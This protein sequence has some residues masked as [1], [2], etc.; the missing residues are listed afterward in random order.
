M[1]KLATKCAPAREPLERAYRAGFHYAELWLDGTVLAAWETAAEYARDYPLSY[2]IHFP[3]RLELST[4]T[5]EQT[6]ALYR[7][8]RPSCLIIHGPMFHRFADALLQS[9]PNLVLA[10]EN[11]KFTPEEFDVWAAQSPGLTL[12]VEHLWKYTLRDAP[13]NT[14]VKRVRELLAR[15][16]GKLRHVHLPGYWPGFDEHRPMYSSKEMVWPIL[17]LLQETGFKGL[18][19]SEVAMAH[20]NIEE[21]RMDVLF[22]DAW[23][24]LQLEPSVERS[25]GPV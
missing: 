16:G 22:F 20:Q 18:V 13:L 9:E 25:P 6:V 3:N 15:Y 7:A 2:A 5:V 21:L 24:R 10:V 1:L 12:D 23:R 14:L 8:L 11:H 4:A 19:V 17:S